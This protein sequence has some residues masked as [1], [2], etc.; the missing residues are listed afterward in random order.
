M[1]FQIKDDVI[2]MYISYPIGIVFF[3]VFFF[4]LVLSIN[5][6]IIQIYV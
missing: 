2:L 3:F 5:L 1:L 6:K 4:L